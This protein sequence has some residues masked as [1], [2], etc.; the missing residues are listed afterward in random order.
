MMAVEFVADKVPASTRVW[1]TVQTL[2]RI[3][4]G[5]ALAAGVFGG[6]SARG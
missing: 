4:A 2:I 3:P 5:A 1:D 6:D